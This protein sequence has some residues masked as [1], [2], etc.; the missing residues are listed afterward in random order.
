M[1]TTSRRSSAARRRTWPRRAG[2]VRSLESFTER[3]PLLAAAVALMHR[4]HDEFEL[5][6]PGSTTVTTPVTR[7]SRSGTACARTSRT[8]RSRCLR[9]LGLPRAT[10]AATCSRTR[11]PDS[12]GCVGADAS[13]AWV[14]VWC[15]RNGWVDLDPTN[16]VLADTARDR[17]LGPRLRRREPAARRDPRR[18]P[19]RRC[20]SASASSRSERHDDQRRAHRALR[21]KLRDL[22]DLCVQRPSFNL[23]DRYK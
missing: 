14:S 23:S 1:G 3:R 18:R 17:R 16:D 8:S 11:R 19:A 12:R 5:P 15:P 6:T 7:C 21:R 13:H 20:T 9:S 4:I 22:C 2:G 10:S